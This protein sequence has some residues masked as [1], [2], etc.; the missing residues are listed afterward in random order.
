VLAR[1]PGRRAR[2]ARHR[3][4]RDQRIDESA[5]SGS[6]DAVGGDHGSFARLAAAGVSVLHADDPAVTLL[7]NAPEDLL[8]VDLAGAR[9]A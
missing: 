9:L 2:R 3:P 6:T 5:G 1:W 4:S 8:V 7:G